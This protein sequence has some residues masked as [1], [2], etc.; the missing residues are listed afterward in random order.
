MVLKANWLSALVL[1][2]A[3]PSCPRSSLVRLTA[4]REQHPR[5]ERCCSRPLRSPTDHPTPFL[6]SGVAI[7]CSA[8]RREIGVAGLV[9]AFSGLP[10]LG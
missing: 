4:G 9:A 7:S 5:A 1:L 2:G 10:C 6:A 3:L 8:P